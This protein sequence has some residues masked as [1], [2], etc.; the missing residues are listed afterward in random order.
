MHMKFTKPLLTYI[1]C[2][3]RKVILELVHVEFHGSM[4]IDD[5]KES[6]DPKP[7]DD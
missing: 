5:P 4:D 6:D 2:Y 7:Y 1:I 3:H